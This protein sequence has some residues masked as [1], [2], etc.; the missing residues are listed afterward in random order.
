MSP[1]VCYLRK[2]KFRYHEISRKLTRYHWKT[3]EKKYMNAWP[4][5]ASIHV[6]KKSVELKR[7][8]SFKTIL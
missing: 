4:F 2:T 3:E 5:R 6:D 7:I 1:N 8:V